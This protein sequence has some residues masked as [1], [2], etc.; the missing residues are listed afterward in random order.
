MI[1]NLMV[2]SFVNVDDDEDEKPMGDGIMY[3]PAAG[4]MI[5]IRILR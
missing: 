1:I 3:A 4:H 5:C 2:L